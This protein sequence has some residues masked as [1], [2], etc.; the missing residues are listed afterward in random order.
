MKKSVANVSAG[1]VTPIED[2]I[3]ANDGDLDNHS[4][5]TNKLKQGLTKFKG[6]ISN[7]ITTNIKRPKNASGNDAHIQIDTLEEN[8]DND[9]IP[10]P[11]A[12]IGE[13]NIISEP[14]LYFKDTP[15]DSTFL[16]NESN[17]F[18]NDNTFF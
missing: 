11:E 14:E 10:E 13:P 7:L 17:Y 16:Q 12:E 18:S 5:L 6:Y 3:N 1:N 2:F 15:N 8:L 4:K 9:Y